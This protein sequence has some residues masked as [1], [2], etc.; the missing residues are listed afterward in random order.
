MI[1]AI[2]AFAAGAGALAWA[3]SRY[4]ATMLDPPVVANVRGRPVAVSL[5]VALA[6]AMIFTIV[7]AGLGVLRSG[8]APGGRTDLLLAASIA[9]IFLAGLHDDRSGG[10]A[11]GLRGH[12]S[13]LARGRVTSGIVK[14]V[15]AVAAATVMALALRARGAELWAGI[16]F[17]AGASN[18]FN[19]LDVAPGRA[20]KWGLLGA[21]ALVPVAA[22]VAVANLAG[23]LV[24]LLPADLRERAMLGDA[25]SNVIGFALGV[26]LFDIMATGWLWVALA[27]VVLLHVVAETV[28]LSRVIDA[29]PPLRWFDRIGRFP[30]PDAGTNGHV[31][32]RDP[33]I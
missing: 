2:L 19:L 30:D 24:V 1:P 8:D 9:S 25:G 26:A 15:V 11:R 6:V 27:V 23:A 17:I 7:P 21:V 4:A 22:P 12:L 3:T 16:P 5:G 14:L 32:A 10:R 20:Q 18:A 31:T 13:A 28:T 33:E 29:V